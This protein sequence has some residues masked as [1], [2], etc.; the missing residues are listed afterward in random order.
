M[1]ELLMLVLFCGLFIK[2]LGLVF[3]ATWGIA[4]LAASILLAIACP[5][6][7]LCLIFAGGVLLL[8]PVAVVTVAFG[9]IKAC[10]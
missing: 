8:V 2:V 3:R 6:L 5:M 9:I 1:L 7:V 4:K 10:I